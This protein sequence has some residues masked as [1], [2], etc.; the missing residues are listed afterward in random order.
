MLA[1]PGLAR[2]SCAEDESRQERRT[3]LAV[4]AH[5][6]DIEIGCAGT[7]VSH[8][9]AGDRVVMLV[10]SDGERGPGATAAQ[11]RMEQ[12]RA[13]RAIGAELRWGNLPD[14]RIT[15][16]LESVDVIEQLVREIRADIVYTHAPDD[17]HQDH[18]ATSRAV[19]SAARGVPTLLFYE[20]PTSLGFSPAVFVDV[21]E[22]AHRKLAALKIHASQVSSSDRVDPTVIAALLRIR[23]AHGR[24][25][26]A[27]GFIARRLML[28]AFH[29]AGARRSARPAVVEKPCSCA[30]GEQTLEDNP[31]RMA[32]G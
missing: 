26:Y 21:T 30:A 1:I 31:S 12:E 19:E 18:R 16:G 23:G 7:L 4:G 5:P 20:S 13:A 8:V 24:L 25:P 6:D 28:P 3:V 9:E 22:T 29:T 11:R 10:L 2:P 15:D 27:E 17:S 14:G 32:L